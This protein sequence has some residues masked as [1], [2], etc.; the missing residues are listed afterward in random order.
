MKHKYSV[1]II[2]YASN[3]VKEAR[4]QGKHLASLTGKDFYR[5]KYVHEGYDRRQASA[6]FT[7]Y[8]QKESNNPLA[9]SIALQ[10]DYEN[11]VELMFK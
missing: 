6:K 9:Y 11:I 10:K 8:A 1:L 4:K 3:E 2:Y 5:A 7:E